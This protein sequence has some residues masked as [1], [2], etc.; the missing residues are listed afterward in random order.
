MSRQAEKEGFIG[1]L[2]NV[3]KKGSRTVYLLYLFY[4]M[5]CLPYMCSR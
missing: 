1:F 2:Q 5:Q 4:G 3:V